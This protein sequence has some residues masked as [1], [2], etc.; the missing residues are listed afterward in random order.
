MGGKGSGPQ[1]GR[2]LSQSARAAISLANRRIDHV[3]L[4]K[5]AQIEARQNDRQGVRAATQPVKAG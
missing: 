2:K 4:L 3:A 1:A 5:R